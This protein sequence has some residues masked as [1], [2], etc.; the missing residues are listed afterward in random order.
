[1]LLRPAVFFLCG[2]WEDLKLSRTLFG[3]VA[4]LLEGTSHS[5]GGAG[6]ESMLLCL[7]QLHLVHPL[8]P[9]SAARWETR[10]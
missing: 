8:G 4:P 9:P 7:G 5:R 3:I 10:W 1:M 2:K 6:C